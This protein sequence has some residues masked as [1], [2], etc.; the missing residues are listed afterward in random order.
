MYTAAEVQRI[1]KICHVANRAWCQENGDA[2][3]PI[4]ECASGEARQSAISGVQAILDLTVTSPEQSHENWVAQKIKDGWKYGEKKNEHKREHPCIV[5]YRK[6][7]AL[8]QQ[9]DYLFFAIVRSFMHDDV[10]ER[11]SDTSPRLP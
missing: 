7:S 11:A 5:P 1:A 2:S 4:W 8:Q 3:Q 6:L 9:K 10:I